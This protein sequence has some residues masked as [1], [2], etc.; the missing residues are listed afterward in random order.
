[1]DGLTLRAPAKLNLTLEVD[2]PRPDGYH[3][4]RSLMAEL[5]DLFDDVELATSARRRV[6][7]PGVPERENL[8]WRAL[9]ALDAHVGRVLGVAVTITKRI[10]SQAGLGGGSSDAGATLVGANRLFGLG[11]TDEVLIELAAVVGSDVPFFIRGG[12]QRASGRGDVLE[13]ATVPTAWA[14]L[15]RIP[16]GL[17]T[18]MVYRAFD[19]MARP[20]RVPTRTVRSFDELVANARNDLWPAALALAPALG[21]AARELAA[22]GACR[23][24]LCGS[25]STVA[26]LVRTAADAERIASQVTARVP[27]AWV[28]TSALGDPTLAVPTRTTARVV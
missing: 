16:I 7:C 1:M 20:V 11:L 23:V 13:P 4:I 5:P 3:P 19:R 22:A 8:A 14:V 6:I 26:G 15:A 10:P 28:D 2:P 25:G 12:T 24:L 17:P 27:N 18:P 21:R 9:D